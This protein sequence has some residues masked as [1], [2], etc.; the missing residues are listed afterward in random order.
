MSNQ[1][2]CG[3]NTHSLLGRA[4]FKLI[5]YSRSASAVFSCL[6]TQY[7]MVT[8]GGSIFTLCYRKDNGWMEILIEK[9]VSAT[10]WF[11]PSPECTVL[12]V[13]QGEK[14]CFI[15]SIFWEVTQRGLATEV[16]GQPVCP[17]SSVNNYLSTPRNITEERR[18]HLR[19]GG[20]LKSFW[21]P[22]AEPFLRR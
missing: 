19:L 17:E 8:F 18:Y 14:P 16:S 5:Y 11:L 4:D 22:V 6:S 1:P 21:L 3:S 10:D 15:L 9:S 2:E 7:V 20:D 13:L 12:R